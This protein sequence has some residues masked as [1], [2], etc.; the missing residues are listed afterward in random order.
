MD[1]LEEERE[2][3]TANVTLWWTLNMYLSISSMQW[4]DHGFLHFAG[5]TVG[6][7][8]LRNL[9]DGWIEE[10]RREPQYQGCV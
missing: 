3:T 2:V 4:R 6:P 9:D 5:G 7:E 8:K 10:V 1:Y